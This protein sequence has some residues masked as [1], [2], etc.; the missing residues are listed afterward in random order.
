MNI[1]VVR[2]NA[3]VSGGVGR[4]L[5]AVV[6]RLMTCIALSSVADGHFA[7]AARVVTPL[8][9]ATKTAAVVIVFR[10]T[11]ITAR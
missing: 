7:E 4:L 9:V 11:G 8:T 1:V 3:P 2:W 10:M 6:V 5:S